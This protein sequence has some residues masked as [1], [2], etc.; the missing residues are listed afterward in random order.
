[1]TKY[2]IKKVFYKTSSKIAI[3]VLLFVMGITCF[4]A[5]SVSWVD[6]NGDKH[7]GPAAVSHLRAARKEWTGYLDEEKISEVIEENIRIRTSP[8]ALSSN[9]QELEIAYGWGQGIM[10]IRDL[11]NSSFATRFREY[12]YYRAD[13]LT[14]ED[15]C[16]FYSNRTLLL[17]EWL[18]DEVK[19]EFTESEKEFLINQ[20]E[21]LKTPLYYDYMTGW[22]QLFEY[23]STIV[24]ITMLVLSYLVAGIFSNE[25]SLKSDAIFFTSVYGR[26]KAVMAK[27]KA[28]FII[29][30]LVYFAAF[31]VYTAITLLYLGADGW[32]LAIQINYWKSFYNITMWQKYILIAIGGYI[33]CLF[34]SFVTMMASA[35]TKS[36]VFAVMIPVILLFIPSF[37]GNIRSHIIQK[38]LLGLLPDQLLD[39]GTALNVF[40]IYSFFGIMVGAVPIIMVLYTVLTVVIIPFLY[41]EYR[42]KQIA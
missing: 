26:N 11:L 6:E 4:F 9:T 7:T 19:Y 13:S 34:I 18:E 28:G 5:T 16:N 8:E 38:I 3:L 23:A 31:I 30:T 21:S 15:A 24:M 36:T 2:E 35:K 27:I 39:I 22:S 12:D 25:F 32:N 17:R 1:M 29:V 33:G 40:N 42:H 41:K 14:K 10:D 20:Y 37:T